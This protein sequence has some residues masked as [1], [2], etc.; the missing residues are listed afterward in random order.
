MN[1]NRWITSLVGAA[2]ISLGTIPAR[3]TIII[4][5]K[6]D[7]QSNEVNIHLTGGD[8]GTTVTGT[9]ATTLGTYNVNFSSTQTLEV[10]ASGK[11]QAFIQATDSGKQVGLTN[12]TISLGSGSPTSTF[13][14][15]ILNLSNGG[16]FTADGVTITVNSVDSMG[17]AETPTTL[18]DTN[19]TNGSNFY[20]IVASGGEAITQ[21]ERTC[22][23]NPCPARICNLVHGIQLVASSLQ[24]RIC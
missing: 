15:F 2:L 5:N 16:K 8:T 24:T 1:T 10:V 4:E 19:L 11:G 22:F 21:G 14:D 13:E 17:N 9:A 18:T 7:P 6:N 12:G 23:A 3:A 20:T